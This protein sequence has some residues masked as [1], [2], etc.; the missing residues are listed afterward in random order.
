MIMRRIKISR[1]LKISPE[2]I[3]LV[4]LLEI[5]AIVTRP[6]LQGVGIK[7]KN[8]AEESFEEFIVSKGNLLIDNPRKSGF[9]VGGAGFSFL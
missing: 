2:C 4:L 5:N 9:K 8:L 1:S 7:F 3:Q 6:F